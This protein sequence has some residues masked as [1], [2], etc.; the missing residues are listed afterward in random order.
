MAKAGNWQQLFTDETSR[1]QI[2]I[3]NLI[4][5]INED[6]VFKN[7]VLS[8]SIILE[9]ESS[10]EQLHAILEMLKRGA[11][12]TMRW[13]EVIEKM[14][15]SYKHDIPDD[16]EINTSKLGEGGAINS[17]TCNTARKTRRI[18]IEEI[19]TE[20]KIKGKEGKHILEVD[21]WNY[22]RNVWL[23]GMTKSLST[24]LKDY[25]GSDLDCIDSR[26]RVSP[27]IES[28]LRAADKEFSLSANYPKGRGEFFH[29]WIEEHHTGVILFM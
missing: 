28:I 7:I 8:S 26:L 5:A 25:L 24:Y 10:E 3:Q 19:V 22:L 6:N 16:N 11:H 9:G 13:R 4:I 17:D 21:C 18:I 15:P 23:G 27:N 1:R 2:T 20:M 29:K 14:Y 12:R